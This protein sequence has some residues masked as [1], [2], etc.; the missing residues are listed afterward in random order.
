MAQDLL[1]KVKVA[2]QEAADRM[3]EVDKDEPPPTLMLRRA[4]DDL[5]ALLK[6]RARRTFKDEEDQCIGEVLDVLI[7]VT[8]MT[9]HVDTPKLF[10]EAVRLRLEV[11]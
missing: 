2:I 6:G 3:E 9:R 8:T 1:L 7:A 10:A 4:L 5:G 11:I